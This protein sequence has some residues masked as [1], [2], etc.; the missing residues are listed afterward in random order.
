MGLSIE[1]MDRLRRLSLTAPST[2]IQRTIRYIQVDGNATPAT[3]VV[4][5]SHMK[6]F[7]KE[8]GRTDWIPLVEFPLELLEEVKAE[9]E[10]KLRNRRNMVVTK[11]MLSKLHSLASSNSPVELATWCLFVSGRRFAEMMA[12][13]FE[14]HTRTYIVTTDLK[15]KRVQQLESFALLP[16]VS[17]DDWLDA[18]TTVRNSFSDVTPNAVNRAVSRYLKLL[19]GPAMSAHKLR[20]IYANV[21]WHNSGG[22]QIKTGFIQKALNLESQDIAINYSSY[23]LQ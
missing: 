10:D 22:S 14:R 21:L 18:V 7:F 12:S 15:K 16:G 9:R 17:S 11:D 6:R 19:F 1:H 3:Q 4:R 2:V 5:L 13:Q 23:I 20:G 8:T